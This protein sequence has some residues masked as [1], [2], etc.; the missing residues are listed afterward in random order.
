MRIGICRYVRQGGRNCGNHSVPFYFET[1]NLRELM[2]AVYPY[3]GTVVK[4]A[5]GL[6]SNRVRIFCKV[7]PQQGTGPLLRGLRYVSIWSSEKR[8]RRNGRAAVPLGK[9]LRLCR[10]KPAFLA[11]RLAGGRIPSAWS[12]WHHECPNDASALAWHDPDIDAA[13]N[14]ALTSYRCASCQSLGFKQV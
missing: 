2:G 14:S 4:W 3:R 9:V 8:Q 10:T 6:C 11:S 13:L 12:V 7:T 1:T 5:R